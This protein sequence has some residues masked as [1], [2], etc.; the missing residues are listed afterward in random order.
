MEQSVSVN[1]FQEKTLYA[2]VPEGSDAL[3]VSELVAMGDDV[4]F[5]LRDDKRM[6]AAAAGFAF[7]SPDIE[8]IK[9]PAWDCLPYDRVSPRKDIVAQRIHAMTELLG[10]SSVRGRIILVSIAALLQRVPPRSIFSDAVLSVSQK[11]PLCRDRL[12]TF[13]E[14][15]SYERCETVITRDRKVSTISP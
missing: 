6:S 12:L 3:V 5:V 13:L 1:N 2:G 10:S 7:F 15:N 9:F 14:K 4:L 11:D 8:V